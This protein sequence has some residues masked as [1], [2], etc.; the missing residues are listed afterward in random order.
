MRM[1]ETNPAEFEQYV[2][3]AAD[4]AKLAVEQPQVFASLVGGDT[5]VDGLLEERGAERGSLK[6]G[7]P[8]LK[9]IKLNPVQLSFDKGHQY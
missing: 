4:A 5:G 3:M 2:Q 6:L 9:K 8:Y 1:K 7:G